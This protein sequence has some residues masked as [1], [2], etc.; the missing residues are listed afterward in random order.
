MQLAS[1]APVTSPAYMTDDTPQLKK[2]II[3]LRWIGVYPD[4]A[5]AADRA[6]IPPLPI[7]MHGEPRAGQ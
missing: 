5:P 3:K 1:D 7:R 2:L 6:G 4:G